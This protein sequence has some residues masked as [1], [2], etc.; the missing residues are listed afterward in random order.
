MECVNVEKERDKALTDKKLVEEKLNGK[1]EECEKL[2]AH[3]DSLV[4]QS[5]LLAISPGN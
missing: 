3:Y 4:K 5:E 1:N 2:Q